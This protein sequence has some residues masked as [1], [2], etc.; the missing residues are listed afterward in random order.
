M[1]LGILI[2][3]LKTNFGACN[4]N[5]GSREESIERAWE[6]IIEDILPLIE[7]D[8]TAL[9]IAEQILTEWDDSEI[10][11]EFSNP[12]E[13]KYQCPVI[14]CIWASL[15]INSLLLHLNDRH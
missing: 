7:Q 14:G 1:T 3:H 8:V 12:I 9:T 4:Y 2:A 6:D 13:E 11:L 5:F 15:S 10:A